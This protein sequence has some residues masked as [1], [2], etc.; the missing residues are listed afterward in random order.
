MKWIEVETTL[1]NLDNINKITVCFDED[2]ISRYKLKFI[3]QN[4]D[5]ETIV[6]SSDRDLWESYEWLKKELN[7]TTEL[8]G[9]K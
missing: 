4:G 8:E 7:I 2:H 9:I 5:I 6:Y 1:I 3:F